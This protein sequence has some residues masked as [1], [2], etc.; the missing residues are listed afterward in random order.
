MT[1]RRSVGSHRRMRLGAA[2]LA[3]VLSTLVLLS[4]S[5]MVSG[6]MAPAPMPAGLSAYDAAV[7]A[8][9]PVA[10]WDMRASGRSE[11]D[12]TGHRH[13]G[14]YRPG[15]PT[16]TPLPDGEPAASFD[17]HGEYMTVR[18]SPPFSI[19]T[20]R[21]LSWEGWIRPDVLRFS[22]RSDP[23]RYGYVDWMGKCQSYSPSCEWE[24]RMY[25]AVN[26]EHRCDRLSAYVFNPGAGL[27]SAADWQ[28]RC[29]LIAAG[30]WLYVVGEYQTSVTP[31]GCSRKHPGAISIWVNG[32]KQ[33]FADHS[34]TGCMSEYAVTPR[35]GRSALNIGTMARDTWFPG[36]IGKVALYDTLLGQAQIDAHFS[37]MTGAR[38]SGSCA[39]FCTI[40]VP[41]Q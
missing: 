23:Q 10:F 31:R 30:Q 22:R 27:G 8:D 38:P 17:G 34:P 2:L 9:H 39:N 32:V 13:T 1:R 33:D 25:S 7:L 35:S 21:A 28:P 37:A 19:R 26:A 24:A 16:R 15:R 29:H 5:V 12:L 11:A 41:T 14:T 6:Q 40:P 4:L 36:A 20:T 3:I 18:S